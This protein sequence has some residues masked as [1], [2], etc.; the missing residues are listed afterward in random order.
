MNCISYGAH[1]QYSHLRP[2]LFSAIAALPPIF[3]AYG[4]QDVYKLVDITGAYGGVG[5]Q[6]FIPAILAYYSR[7][8]MA[9]VVPELSNPYASQFSHM[10]WVVG[11]V[12]MTILSL[13]ISTYNIV[14]EAIKGEDDLDCQTILTESK[15]YY[16]EL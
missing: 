9:E 16:F 3:I 7:K 12:V 6:W 1:S 5:I 14:I 11:L 4:T 8:A 13:F 2:Y 10:G 15:S